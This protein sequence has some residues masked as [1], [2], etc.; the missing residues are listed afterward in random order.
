M[1]CDSVGKLIPLYFYGELPSEEED[2]VEAHLHECAACTRELDR[3]T[4]LAETLSRRSVEVPANLLEDCRADLKAAVEG[5]APLLKPAAKG[6]WTL[7][8]EALAATLPSV[9]RL[10][11][12]A[13][14]LAML[15]LGFF[16]ARYSGVGRTWWR[17][18]D[19][20]ALITVQSIQQDPSGIVQ[21]GYDEIHHL[22][23][24]GRANS[25]DIQKLVLAGMS[26]P[27]A[28]VQSV[29]LLDP[30][31]DTEVRDALLSDLEHDSNVGVR[32]G[33]LNKLTPM[34]SQADVRKTLARVLQTDENA[35]VR[36]RIV[37]LLTAQRD[38]SLVGVMQAQ[39]QRE[40]NAGV[41]QKLVKALKDMNAS[42]GTF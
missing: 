3:L 11:I 36:M 26:N 28:R 23:A 37:D 19:D 29:A 9:S 5:G 39:V 33:I 20:S 14:A 17:S 34:V 22:V 30:Q 15:A 1:T 10:R 18:A 42:V 2:R 35:A 41:Q 21:V 25:P 6:P 27:G 31:T 16:A 12:P 32:L 8:L 40:D 24:S 4:A 13:G 7:F 38:D